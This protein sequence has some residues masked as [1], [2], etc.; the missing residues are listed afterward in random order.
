MQ[1][2]I[3]K[4]QKNIFDSL[5]G[6]VGCKDLN[7]VFLYGNKVTTENVGLNNPED[8]LGRT[9]LDVPCETCIKFHNIWTEQDNIVIKEKTSLEILDVQNYING[10]KAYIT[11]RSPL[12]NEDRTNVI[13]TIYQGIDITRESVLKIFHS[14]SKRI[15]KTDSIFLDGQDSRILTKNIHRPNLTIKETETLFL[16]IFGKTAKDIAKIL[17]I[18]QRTVVEYTEDLKIKFDAKN[19]SELIDKSYSLGIEKFIPKSLFNKNLSVIL[20]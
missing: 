18:S 1:I 4:D 13:G 8:I 3:T 14:L 2:K 6:S 5:R 17:C 10:F 16:I 15:G 9:T 12:W 7:S 19:K 11:K 20:E